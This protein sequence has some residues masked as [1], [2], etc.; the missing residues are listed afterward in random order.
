MFRISLF[1]DTGNISVIAGIATPRTTYKSLHAAAGWHDY[2]VTVA[3]KAMIED[4]IRPDFSGIADSDLALTA[5]QREFEHNRHMFLLLST[6]NLTMP[7]TI[8]SAVEDLAWTSKSVINIHLLG[9]SGREFLALNIFEEILHLLPALKTL[10]MTAVGPSAWLDQGRTSGHQVLDQVSCCPACK[11]LG[12]SRPFA[13]YKG[14][15]HKF[16]TTPQYEKPDL[17]VA[18]NSGWVD[19]D[20]AE[21]DWQQTIRQIVRSEVAALFTTYDSGE[22]EHER[23]VLNMLRAKFVV[24]PAENK[25]KGLVPTPEFVDEE[26]GLWHQNNWS[27]IIQ[28]LR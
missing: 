10:R 5:E 8:V 18:F 16:I 9:A 7:L 19:G 11:T 20:D 14:L 15:Y 6:D 13:S 2:F 3:D 12:R 22:V 27:Y 4:H 25:W 24:E 17:I 23:S 21:S 1:E 26:F 28:G